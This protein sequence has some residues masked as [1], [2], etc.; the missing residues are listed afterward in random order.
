MSAVCSVGS[1]VT[2]V[3]TAANVCGV[4]T[5]T[6]LVAICINPSENI[7]IIFTMMNQ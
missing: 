4:S 1:V 2:A 5:P 7:G 3:D 6:R